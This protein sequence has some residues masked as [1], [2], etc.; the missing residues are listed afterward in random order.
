MRVSSGLV[1]FF[2]ITEALVGASLVLYGWVGTNDSVARAISV[3][4]HLVNTFL[5]LAAITT[6]AWWATEG[7]P[8]RL[9]LHGISGPFL[10]LGAAAILLL[11]ASGAI[12]ALGDTLFPSG[13][14]AQGFQ[15]DF[16]PTAHYLIRMRVYHPGIAVS[17]GIYLFLVTGYIRRKMTAPYL[18]GIT[19]ILFGLYAAQILL[20]I[21]N[22]ALLAPLWMQVIHLLI[23]NLVWVAFVL[24]TVVVLGNPA[25]R[26]EH[27][28]I[29]DSVRQVPG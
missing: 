10:L 2:T 3:M 21:I 8:E 16:S 27:H 13:S 17:V 23:S 29:Q 1:L 7:V 6:T 20:G 4:V 9:S 26:L 15:E 14:L 19:N 24:M 12:T 22:I 28:E 11:G 18:S 5:L 25:L